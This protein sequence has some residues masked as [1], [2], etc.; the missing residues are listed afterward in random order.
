MLWSV[1]QFNFLLQIWKIQR[2]LEGKE[3]FTWVGIFYKKMMSSSGL[4]SCQKVYFSIFSIFIIT[5]FLDEL[6][7]GFTHH[8][9]IKFVYQ[10]HLRLLKH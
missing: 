5:D 7:S 8:E 9:T 3:S 10:Y 2:K 1:P 4:I 6:N